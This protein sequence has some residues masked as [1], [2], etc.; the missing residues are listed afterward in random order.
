MAVTLALSVLPGEYAIC[1]LQSSEPI[2]Q[3]A[4]GNG[5]FSATRAHDELSIVC[6]KDRI[7]EEYEIDD[8]WTA[9]MFV[10]TFEFDEAGI[11]LS[12]IEPL[13]NSE[14]G[15]FAISTF[16]R[17]YLLIKRSDLDKAKEILKVAGHN[18]I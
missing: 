10:G 3:W 9:I 2:P 8:G 15:L 11:V 4:E 7:P 16:K 12:I 14:I 5:L 18:F 1:L 17:D 6:R 13:S